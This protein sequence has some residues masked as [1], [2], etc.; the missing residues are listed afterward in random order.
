MKQ[1][2]N[3]LCD[4]CKINLMEHFYS[5]LESKC[6][7]ISQL[8]SI[9]RQLNSDVILKICEYLINPYKIIYTKYKPQFKR[10][11][12]ILEDQVS[13][14]QDYYNYNLYSKNYYNLECNKICNKCFQRAI[15]N[16]A[17]IRSKKICY[18]SNCNIN[19]RFYQLPIKFF[20]SM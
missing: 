15:F 2:S 16:K 20:I 8:T 19:D 6:S 11:P 18:L 9:N 17:I 13:E 14:K 5:L 10:F 7:Q 12:T 1:I 3:E 4:Y